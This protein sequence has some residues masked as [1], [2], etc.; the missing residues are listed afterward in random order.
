MDFLGNPCDAHPGTVANGGY[1]ARPIKTPTTSGPD[2]FYLTGNDA[3]RCRKRL[4]AY[5]VSLLRCS[6]LHHR[7][8]TDGLELIAVALETNPDRPVILI[9]GHGD[10]PMAVKEMSNRAYDFIEKPFSS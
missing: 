5:L 7:T 6:R 10:V 4:G 9:T 8:K 2:K 3:R 1:I